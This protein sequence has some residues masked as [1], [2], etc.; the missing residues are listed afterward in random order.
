MHVRGDKHARVGIS[1][2]TA[3]FG[4][5]GETLDQLLIVADQAMYRVKS[6]HKQTRTTALTIPPVSTSALIAHPINE[7][8]DD[9][10]ASTSVN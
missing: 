7:R 2:G 6:D 3:T 5:D 8:T 10:L 4:I 9:E 1:V